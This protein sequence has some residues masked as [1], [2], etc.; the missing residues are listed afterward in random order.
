VNVL[1]LEVI[2]MY[3]ERHNSNQLFMFIFELLTAISC[4]LCSN[5]SPTLLFLLNIDVCSHVSIST[6]K[7]ENKLTPR[8][9]TDRTVTC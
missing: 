7:L 2:V 6:K 3:V 9:N 8:F 1:S 5:M 4:M